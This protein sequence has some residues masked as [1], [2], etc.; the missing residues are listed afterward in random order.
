MTTAFEAQRFKPVPG[1]YVFWLPIPATLG[2][3]QAYR[4]TEAQKAEILQLAEPTI[5]RWMLWSTRGALAL[6]VAA[7]RAV[8]HDG[9]ATPWDAVV[10]FL[11]VF[12]TVQIVGSS[13]AWRAMGRRLQ[14]LL[15]GLPRSDERLFSTRCRAY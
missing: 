1:G 8:A 14:P 13:L 6:A 10:A 5:A 3:P 12:P 9:G 2:R 4:V 11:A 15:A 7:G